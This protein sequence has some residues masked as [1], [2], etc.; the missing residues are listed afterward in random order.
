MVTDEQ[1]I[2]MSVAD[3]MET[4]PQVLLTIHRHRLACCGCAMANFC[5]IG[6]V[7]ETYE[8]IQLE[9]FVSELQTAIQEESRQ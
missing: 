4:W 3:V 9:P 2:E 6:D 7:A 1:L 5:R 8:Q